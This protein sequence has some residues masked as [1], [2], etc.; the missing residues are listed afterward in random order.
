LRFDARL[1]RVARLTIQPKIMAR[2]SATSGSEVA[3]RHFS[4]PDPPGRTPF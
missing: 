4:W 1:E 2:P 3:A